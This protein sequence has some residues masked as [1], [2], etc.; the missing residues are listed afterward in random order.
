MPGFDGEDGARG[1]EVGGACDVG[2]GAE[3]GGYADS[4]GSGRWRVR[5]FSW[6]LGRW[7]L[8]RGD[9]GTRGGRTF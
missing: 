7:M 2:G 1:G 9:E 5:G 3:V 6:W 8:D 4:C